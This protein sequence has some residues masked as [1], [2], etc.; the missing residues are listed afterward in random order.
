MPLLLLGLS[1]APTAQPSDLNK[2]RTA[3][4]AVQKVI[5]DALAS[6]SAS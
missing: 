4:L 6:L 3:L 2:A 1:V 5:A